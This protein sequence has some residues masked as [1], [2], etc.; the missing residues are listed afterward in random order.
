M[1]PYVIMTSPGTQKSEPH[2]FFWFH[3]PY[4][5]SIN[6]I[7]IFARKQITECAHHVI[8]QGRVRENTKTHVP[9]LGCMVM[10]CAICESC[11]TALQRILQTLLR[12][13]RLYNKISNDIK[14]NTI[15][16]KRICTFI[17]SKFLPQIA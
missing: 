14:I 12:F 9:Y 8:L 17:L 15:R 5:I 2:V 11:E 16:K 10:V 7:Y 4:H 1:T 6:V 13:H 3:E